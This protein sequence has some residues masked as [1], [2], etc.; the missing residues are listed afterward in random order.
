MK[1]GLQE[2]EATAKGRAAFP[3]KDHLIPIC[4]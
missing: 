3:A 1:R 2:P 4:F